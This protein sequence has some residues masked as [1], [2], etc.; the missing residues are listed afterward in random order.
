MSETLYNACISHK[1][2]VLVNNAGHGLSYPVEK[3]KYIS[4]LVEF[5]NEIKQ[6]K[7]DN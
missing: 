5:E 7:S 1:K 3:E 4:A 6:K 2:L